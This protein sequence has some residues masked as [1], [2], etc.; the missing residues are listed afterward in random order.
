LT[1]ALRTGSQVNHVLVCGGSVV[2]GNWT[3]AAAV[4]N[5]SNMILYQDGNEVGRVAQ[6]GTIKTA[7][8]ASVWIG[9]IP[10]DTSSGGWPGVID[11]PALFPSALS[12]AQV[13]ALYQARR[14]DLTVLNWNE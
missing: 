5:G 1:F 2:S 7:D 3:F 12:A 8:Y 11:D 10:P 13:Q 9:N 4:Y 14:P 6:T